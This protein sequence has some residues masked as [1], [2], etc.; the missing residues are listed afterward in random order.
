MEPEARTA[1]DAK[2]KVYEDGQDGM[3]EYYESELK[4]KMRRH[5]GEHLREPQRTS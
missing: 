4:M 3:N 5:L 1:S 2:I